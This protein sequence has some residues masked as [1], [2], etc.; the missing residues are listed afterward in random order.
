MSGAFEERW[1]ICCEFKHHSLMSLG[2]TEYRGLG[3]KD[4]LCVGEIPNRLDCGQKRAM[5][6]PY[7][8]V[9]RLPARRVAD[10]VP[11]HDHAKRYAEEP[12]HDITHLNT[13]YQIATQECRYVRSESHRAAGLKIRGLAPS[14]AP[15]RLVCESRRGTRPPPRQRMTLDVLRGPPP[16]SDMS[17]PKDYRDLA[18][19]ISSVSVRPLTRW[20]QSEAYDGDGRGRGGSWNAHVA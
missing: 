5:A 4:C 9:I 16:Q 6:R 2:P 14:T 11:E 10:D 12:R 17:V 8:L 13:F 3:E 15:G 1:R 18:K 19:N 20:W 7:R